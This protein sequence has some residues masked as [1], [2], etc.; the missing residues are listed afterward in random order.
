MPS[1]NMRRPE[2]EPLTGAAEG[3]GIGERAT[4]AVLGFGGGGGA[5]I[6]IRPELGG[7]GHGY[8]GGFQPKQGGLG[9]GEGLD[10]GYYNVIGI[11]GCH[12]WAYTE[13]ERPSYGGELWRQDFFS[14]W[15]HW[16]LLYWFRK[17]LGQEL[18][19]SDTWFKGMMFRGI[20][21]TRE[22]LIALE[23]DLRKGLP[24]TRDDPK[25]ERNPLHRDLLFIRRASVEL[26]IGRKV[27]VYASWS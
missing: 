10:S 6:S 23:A 9:S 5:G 21:L 1:L 3:Y 14:W 16:R 22:D 19:L 7:T 8:L 26:M 20:E 4:L 11:N 17:R 18:I 27:Y 24:E 15:A 25:P 12:I 2:L 13:T